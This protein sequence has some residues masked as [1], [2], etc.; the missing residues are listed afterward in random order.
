MSADDVLLYSINTVL[1]L[2]FI[3]EKTVTSDKFAQR[4]IVFRHGGGGCQ[5]QPISPGGGKAR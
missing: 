1:Y 3:V 5:V 4:V 2:L